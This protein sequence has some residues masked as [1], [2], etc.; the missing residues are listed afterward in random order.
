MKTSKLIF[1]LLIAIVLAIVLFL[2]MFITIDMFEIIEIPEK[3]SLLKN[4]SNTSEIEIKE[5][6]NN[7]DN[8][9]NIKNVENLEKEDIKKLLNK[10]KNIK[11]YECNYKVLGEKINGKYN[12]NILITEISN[13]KI[14][15]DL[16][17]EEYILL[18]EDKKQAIKTKINSNSIEIHTTNVLEAQNESI[19][20]MLEDSNYKY[21]INKEEKY[22]EFDCI[23]LEIEHIFELPKEGG[24]FTE[25]AK[26]NGKTINSKIW[27]DKE[28]GVIIKIISKASEEII[29]EYEF[30]FNKLKDEDFKI[31][32]NGYKITEY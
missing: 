10:T 13:T 11:N 9:E 2:V 32:L 12:E 26:Y 3:Y 19:L 17:K 22:K 8:I 23:V 7:I 16:K 31:N 1:Q 30:T 4:F 18:E 21:K 20:K 28:T 25:L 6:I 15:I 5:E 29:E 24:Y 14:Y 27:I